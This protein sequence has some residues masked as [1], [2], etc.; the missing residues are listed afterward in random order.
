LA[1][2][3]PQ[4]AAPAK[5]GNPAALALAAAHNQISSPSNRTIIVP[6]RIIL[7]RSRRQRDF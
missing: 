1:W 5:D 4:A 7:Q 2:H 6:V 3:F